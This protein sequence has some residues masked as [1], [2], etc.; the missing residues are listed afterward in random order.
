MTPAAS[1][2]P[3]KLKFKDKLKTII[4][5]AEVAQAKALREEQTQ[6]ARSLATD[7]LVQGYPSAFCGESSYIDTC[8][9]VGRVRIIRSF[10]VL[11]ITCLATAGLAMGYFPMQPLC[12]CNNLLSD[13]QTFWITCAPSTGQGIGC[14]AEFHAIA[15]GSAPMLEPKSCPI[16][17]EGSAEAHTQTASE[18]LSIQ[19]LRFAHDQLIKA[20]ADFRRGDRFGQFEAYNQLGLYF[21]QEEMLPLAAYQYRRCLSVAEDIKWLDGQMATETAL[22]LGNDLSF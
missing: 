12:S 18:G 21:E 7:L 19:T 1:P 11:F 9:A 22:G 4:A 20:D 17:E 8:H 13:I 14:F 3:E 2:T 5:E 6:D 10:L 16:P 15:N